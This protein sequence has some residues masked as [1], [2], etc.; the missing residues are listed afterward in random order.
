M[1]SER[2]MVI[3]MKVL[4]EEQALQLSVMLLQNDKNI[5]DDLSKLINDKTTIIGTTSDK[6]VDVEIKNN[7]IIYI[8]DKNIVA[9]DIGKTR[10]FLNQIVIFNTD[11]ERENYIS[12]YDTV[13]GFVKNTAVLWCYINNEWVQITNSPENIIFIG[14][15]LPELGV[16]DKIYVN[17]SKHNISI[18]S[19]EDEKY[20]CVGEETSSIS[21]QDIDKVIENKF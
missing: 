11:D 9:F 3:N 20:I 19:K 12:A 10:K 14:D 1:Y 7:Q 15:V 21:I 18:W 16:E 4:S 2:K 13:F 17:R 8:E 5:K 6:L